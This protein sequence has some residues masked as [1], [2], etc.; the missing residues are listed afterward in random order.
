MPKSHSHHYSR[1]PDP[2]KKWSDVFH[3]IIHNPF[4][5][6]FIVLCIL[7]VVVVLVIVFRPKNNTTT[8]AANG[9][10]TVGSGDT[11]TIIAARLGI[12]VVDLEASNPSVDPNNIQIG[13]LLVIPNGT[14]YTAVSGD[15]CDSIAKK[16]NMTLDRL[17]YLNPNVIC[18]DQMKVGQVFL[19]AIGPI[20]SSSPT[21]TTYTVKAGDTCNN[22][23]GIYHITLDQLA[24]ANPGLDCSNLQIGQVLDIPSSSSPPVITGIQGYFY[25]CN[26]T[27]GQCACVNGAVQSQAPVGN[28][29]ALFVFDEN[30]RP[31]VI[32]KGMVANPNYWS[33]YQYSGPASC[34]YKAY[35]LGGSALDWNTE[36]DYV[37]NN[38]LS[39]IAGAGY[40]T[41]IFDVESMIDQSK[42]TQ[43]TALMKQKNMT[44]MLYSF[45]YADRFF[46]GFTPSSF[47]NVDY[48]IPSIYGGAYNGG[49]C[50]YDSICNLDWWLT[51]FGSEA[52]LILGITVGT[53]PAVQKF[54]HK[55]GTVADGGFA[56]YIEWLYS[57][58]SCDASTSVTC[59]SNPC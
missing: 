48:G 33:A 39:A 43:I 13:S 15:S 41:I 7:V 9:C 34:T 31:S 57:I 14:C 46:T 58:G 25:G 37:D 36:A 18:G 12:S 5:V 21:G 6:G 20:T 19:V 32:Q 44:V 24:Q 26:G 10:Y 52:K 55:N 50:N 3:E 8:N 27:N 30:E 56:G 2:Q 54:P 4:I 16:Y 11:M 59:G 35:T 22:I 17:Y 29:A 28:L 1:L 49:N 40:N 53:W 47:A 23:I 51:I 38:L 42:F 45:Q